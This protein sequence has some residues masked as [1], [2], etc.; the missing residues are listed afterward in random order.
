MSAR[1][2]FACIH[3]A[4]RSQMAAAW[5]NHLAD[6][7]EAHAVSAGTEPGSR[8][9]PEVVTVMREVGIELGAA[10]PTRLTPEL[11]AGARLLI[12]MGCGEACP[13]VPGARRTDWPLRDPKG[14]PIEDVRRIREEIRLRVAQLIADEGWSMD[15]LGC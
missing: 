4:G 15:K 5:F 10:I 12:T 13:F 2:V 9:Q 7:Q 11:A 1:V 6:T 3:N 14:L 8:I